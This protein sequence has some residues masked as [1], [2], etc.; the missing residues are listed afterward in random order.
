MFNVK[1]LSDIRAKIDASTILSPEE[2]GEWL[3][4]LDLMND[5]QL[6][7]LEEILAS[8]QSTTPAQQPAR[9]TSKIPPLTHLANIPAGVGERP[10]AVKPATPLPVAPPLP[11]TPPST[12]PTAPQKP[13]AQP[14]KPPVTNQA[15]PPSRPTEPFTPPSVLKPSKVPPP[16]PV[17]PRKEQPAR[18][19]KPLVPPKTVA[20][21]EEEAGDSN[22]PFIIEH[23][24]DLQNLS[25]R[26][27]RKFDKQTIINVVKETIQA[28][29]YYPILGIIEASPLYKS[30][31]E[32]GNLMLQNQAAPLT[33]AEFEFVADLLTHMRFNRW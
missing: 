22:I 18:E 25:M 33:Q 5:K 4:L 3:G 20:L 13:L 30:Y 11:T 24:E 12:P 29:G 32:S 2:K 10:P 28:H 14:A 23:P 15:P 21:P 31:L 9:P 26:T 16:P 27:L 19:L 8:P 1:R 17:M 7:E 6:T